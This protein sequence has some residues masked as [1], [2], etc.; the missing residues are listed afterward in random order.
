M[1]TEGDINALLLAFTGL[2]CSAVSWGWITIW[3]PQWEDGKLPINLLATGALSFSIAFTAILWQQKLLDAK[4]RKEY[5]GPAWFPKFARTLTAW[6]LSCGLSWCFYG[7]FLYRWHDYDYMDAKFDNPELARRCYSF[8]LCAKFLVFW[9]I[10]VAIIA[11]ILSAHAAC[12][13]SR[14]REIVREELQQQKKSKT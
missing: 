10:F 2:I 1:M 9:G 14:V 4:P 7:A 8:S 12:F 13:R 6:F 5:R 11:A 3:T